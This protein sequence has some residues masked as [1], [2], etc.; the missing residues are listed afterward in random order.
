[1]SDV[2]GTVRQAFD[3]YM[4]AMQSL[5]KANNLLSCGPA[6][7]YFARMQ[8]YIEGLFSLAP[9]Q[10]GNRVVLTTDQKCKGTGWQPWAHFLVTGSAGEVRQ[11]DYHSKQFWAD[12]VFDNE[13]WSNRHTF[14]IKQADLRKESA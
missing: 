4:E 14:R 2:L 10:I 7:F 6:E 13:S 11:I 8:E 5:K 1:M 12:V 3:C 9:V